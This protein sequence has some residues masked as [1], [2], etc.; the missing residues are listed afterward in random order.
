MI[1][2]ID[3]QQIVQTLGYVGIALVVF[4]ET[5]IFFIGMILPG[6]SLL[7]TAGFIASQGLLH[8]VPLTLVACIAA[9]LGGM[10]GYTVGAFMGPH[11]FNRK[12]SF[13]FNHDQVDRA[14]VFFEKYGGKTLVLARFIPFIRAIAPAVAGIGKMNYAKY[15][16][17]NLISAIVWGLSTTLLGYWLGAS[18]PNPDKYLLPI[19]AL[20]IV[21]S[22]LPSVIHVLRDEKSRS[23]LIAML[24]KMARR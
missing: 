7:F 23:R 3:L 11:L 14:H 17:Y 1:F 24:K 8:I 22:V 21:L 12:D 10:C 19:I 13:F 15:F 5:G 9:T 20:I 2:G 16:F 4:A 6:D 18:V